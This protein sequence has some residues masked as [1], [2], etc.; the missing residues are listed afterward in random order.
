VHVHTLGM[1]PLNQLPA[2]ISND[3]LSNAHQFF[4]DSGTPQIIYLL[5]VTHC[6]A[7]KYLLR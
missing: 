6:V 5:L 3:R 4:D 7:I 2:Q 1:W